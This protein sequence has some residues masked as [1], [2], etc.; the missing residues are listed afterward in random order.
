MFGALWLAFAQNTSTTETQG[1]EELAKTVE[2]LYQQGKYSEAIPAATQLLNLTEKSVGPEHPDTATRLSDLAQLNLEMGNY[3]EA[4]PLFQ[5]ALTIQE[6]A[7]GLEHLD[8]AR[9]LNSLATLYQSKGDYAKAEPLFERVLAV[10]EKSLGPEHADTGGI[11]NNLALLYWDM[12]NYAKAESLFER[13]NAIAEKTLGPEHPD[14]AMSLNNLAKFYLITG[15]YAKAEPLFQRALTIREKV[16]GPEHPD[17]AWSLNNLGTLYQHMGEYAKAEPFFQRALTIREKVLGLDHRTTAA[18]F[19]NLALLYQDMGNYAKA[20]QLYER[21][22]AIIEKAV[23]PEHRDTATSVNN[24]AMFYLM[25]GDYAQA[26]PLFQQA[27]AIYEKVLGPEHPDT[28]RSLNNLAMLYCNMGAYAKAEPLF[29][30]A[31]SLNEKAFGPMHSETATTMNNL[32]C[33]YEAT[34]D[35]AKAEPLH[36][37]ALE[38][39]EKVLGPEHPYVSTSLCNLAS[40]YKFMGNY[41]N[42]ELLLQRGLKICEKVLGPEHPDTASTL[43]SLALLFLDQR[44]QSEA[45]EME[46]KAEKARLGMLANL[47]SFTSER[48]RLA[49]QTEC[50]PYGVFATLGIGPQ[51]A[52]AIVHN[53]GIVLDS[54]LEDRLVAQASQN[55]EERASIEQARAAK[56]RLTQLLLEAPTDLSEEALKTRGIEREK[57]AREVERLEGGLARSIAGLGRARSALAV[58]VEQVQATMPKQAV[59]VELLRYRHYLGKTK[60]EP[61]YGAVVMSG[62]GLPQWVCLGSATNV[63]QK[64]KL[65]LQAMR[66]KIDEAELSALLKALYQQL[67]A[68]LESLL[69]AGTR[70]LILSPDG[71]LSFVSFA[72]LPTPDGRFLAEKYSIHYVASGRDLLRQ[73]KPGQG[74]EMAVYANPDFSGRA[75]VSAQAATNDLMAMRE[76]ETRDLADLYLPPLPG[77]AKES[78]A[79]EAAAKSW[80]WSVKTYQGTEATEARV[81]AVRSPRILH[82]ATHGFFLPD[83]GAKE[84]NARPGNRGVGGTSEEADPGLN[85]W[86]RPGEKGPASLKNPMHRSGLALAGAQATLDAWKRGEV[87]P[88]DNDGILTAEEAGGLK[89]EG[90]WLVT[91]SACDTGTG[92]VRSGEGVLGLR[93]GFIQA[94]AQ[95]LLLTL[96]S[97]ADEETGKLMVDSMPRR[98]GL[99]MRQGP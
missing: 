74:A 69:P 40:V 86:A 76:V 3:V 49:Y 35:Y 33:L 78:A 50:D 17:T 56:Q 2:R 22:K 36:Q 90:T 9:T 42:A 79:L 21:A 6:K 54:L 14:R 75:L 18:S 52:A 55:P 23:G 4:E 71:Q 99:A 34:G 32:G 8:T 24:L 87:P 44:R 82:L 51:I 48:Q 10:R 39:R 25:M 84:T 20:E 81:R 94:G 85:P 70:T 12:G 83:A 45:L 89:L 47:L 65:Y 62:S 31:L 80:D 29:Q 43:H 64:V 16:L 73:V 88:M 93:R 11:V 59:V 27:K 30:R 15:N 5:R 7:L 38:L 72:T 57:L 67:W 95:N 26:E 37:K 19:N 1:A 63:E 41:T 98:I 28:A 13:A 60:L 61:R 92:E 58:T 46:T 77:A 68:P 66:R 53:K 97:V 91:L 96:W